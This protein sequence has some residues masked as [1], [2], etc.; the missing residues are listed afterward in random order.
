[1]EFGEVGFQH[2]GSVAVRVA[3]DE[4]WSYHIGGSVLDDVEGLSHL[5]ELVGANVRAMAEAEV[6]LVTN[7]SRS[8]SW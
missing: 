2:V 6:N 4:N 3:G 8:S 5:V 7:V 1:M